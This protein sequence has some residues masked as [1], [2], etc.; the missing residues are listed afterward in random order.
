[1]DIVT[2]ENVASTVDEVVENS[3]RVGQT[4]REARER[5]G[6]SIAEVSNRIKFTN[7]QIEALESDDFT[8]LPEGAF[9][10]GFVRGYARLLALDATSML[11]ALPGNA[12]P[13]LSLPPVSDNTMILKTFS[14]TEHSHNKNIYWLI[15][16]GVLVVALGITFS[17]NRSHQVQPQAVVAT[18]ITPTVTS[19]TVEQTINLPMTVDSVNPTLPP[20]T[21]S[22]AA[23]P[24]TAASVTPSAVTVATPPTA[25]KPA[26]V[27]A[28]ETPKV[29]NSAATTATS[30]LHLV[31][32]E[33]TWVSIK[34]KSGKSLANQVSQRGSELWLNGQA[35]FAVTIKRP[36]GVHLFYLG[37]EM[38][39]SAHSTA[40][41]ARL[42][43]E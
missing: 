21:E 6:M 33:N 10:R 29:N 14:M 3:I 39:L 25:Q 31:F 9:L 20:V 23:V 36:R 8:S 37:K 32:I 7:K 13:V 16:G 22:A 19:N 43:L 38:D 26:P 17:L 24:A 18:E 41:V 27:L 5:L 42:T 34:D 2:N 40:D 15:A 30:P 4:L 11:A 28:P 12:E 1:M 35:P